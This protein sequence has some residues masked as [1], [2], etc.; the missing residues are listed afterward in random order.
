MTRD[1]N[2]IDDL[3]SGMTL[4]LLK[5]SGTA[6]TIKSEVDLD[7]AQTSIQDFVT[8]YNDVMKSLENLE[9]LIKR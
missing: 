9:N 3:Y 2:S 5:T 4:D 1:S 6:I 7:A 8:T